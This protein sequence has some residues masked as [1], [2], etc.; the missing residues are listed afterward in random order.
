MHKYYIIVQRRLDYAEYWAEMTWRQLL[1][2]W[3]H[4]TYYRD[5]ER[6][7]PALTERNVVEYPERSKY[8]APRQGRHWSFDVLRGWVAKIKVS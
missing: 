5:E 1:P 4:K 6:M 3:L 2:L 8:F 7:S